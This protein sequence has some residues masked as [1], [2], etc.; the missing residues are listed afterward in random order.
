M[1]G[2]QKPNYAYLC[3]QNGCAYIEACGYMCK[4]RTRLY[5]F[6]S[7]KRLWWWQFWVNFDRMGGGLFCSVLAMNNNV[8]F[9]T[10]LLKIVFA[11]IVSQ[12]LRFDFPY[13]YYYH[14]SPP[15]GQQY[16]LSFWLDGGY[17]WLA[18]WIHKCKQ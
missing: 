12:I 7:L 5:L 16:L 18:G 15:F 6:Y 17:N 2:E 1:F 9:Q 10:F 11:T 3:T 4:D 13:H 14:H 8:P